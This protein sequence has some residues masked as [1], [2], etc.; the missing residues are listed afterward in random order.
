MAGD[1]RCCSRT[2][3]KLAMLKIVCWASVWI[4]GLGSP[5]LANSSGSKRSTHRETS[6]A[7]TFAGTNSTNRHLT[8]SVAE[9]NTLKTAS[10][11]AL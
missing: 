7:D 4:L 2:M 1:I 3:L 11:M 5:D 6:L 9:L 8:V 10:R